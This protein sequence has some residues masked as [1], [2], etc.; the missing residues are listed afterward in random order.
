MTAL[1]WLDTVRA[2]LDAATPGPWEAARPD[3]RFPAHVITGGPSNT[4]LV[5]TNVPERDAAL[6][7]HAQTDLDRMERALRAVLA[8]HEP[9][10]EC[11]NPRH[12][13]PEAG[14]PDCAV[15]CDDCGGSYPCS[16]VATIQEVLG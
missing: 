14:C 15:I 1:E 10:W 5:A 2:R 16:T 4:D 11:G 3:F 13:N 8:L 6:V 7:A 12:T 9:L